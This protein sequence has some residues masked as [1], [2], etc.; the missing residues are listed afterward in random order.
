[1]TPEHEY[2]HEYPAAGPCDLPAYGWADYE[3]ARERFLQRLAAQAR[4]ASAVPSPGGRE[5]G[6]RRPGAG[7]GGGRHTGR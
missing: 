7:P 6:A 2:E 4:A 3:S 1:M 5:P